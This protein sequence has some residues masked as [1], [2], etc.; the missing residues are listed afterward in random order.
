MQNQNDTLAKNF[1]VLLSSQA[2]TWLLSLVLMIFLPR[3]LGPTNVGKL[4]LAIALWTVLEVVMTFGSDEFVVKAIARDTSRASTF[5]G[6]K[7]FLNSGIFVFC[8]I[9]L[10]YT[11]RWFDYPQITIYVVMLIGLEYWIRLFVISAESVLQGMETMEHISIGRILG[12]FFNVVVGVTLLLLG[13]KIFMICAVRIATAVTVFV[14]QYYFLQQTAKF[15]PQVDRKL[16]G[17]FFKEGWPYFLTGISMVAYMQLDIVILSALVNEETIGWY[18]T[19]DQLFGTLLFIPSAFIMSAYPAYVKLS[20]NEFGSLQKLMAKNFDSMLLLG[21]PM[22][23]G[24]LMI[25]N[26]LVLLLYGTG[27]EKSGPVLSAF[28]IVLILTYL[29]MLVGQFLIAIDRHKPWAFVMAIALLLTIP[30][31]YLLIPWTHSAFGNGALGGAFAFIITE[32]GMLLCGFA[33]L[34]QGTLGNANV[35]TTIRVVIAG[36]VMVGSI[37]WLREYF[38]AIPIIT[39][40]VVY[41]GMVLLLKIVPKEDIDSLK[42]MARRMF[43][44]VS[45]REATAVSH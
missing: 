23:L 30:L 40:V 26:Q 41:V 6:T 1:V 20:V 34:P 21:V 38:I 36:L 5:F 4:Y 12:Q 14:V 2:V 37:W 31:D 19:A 7:S 39:G 13:W 29:N 42:E 43:A 22:G 16:F 10:Y 44:R 28:G 15:R 3:Y 18:G 33:L 27:F 32:L 17:T 25:G 11:L 8:F 9:A 35:R 45:R 24:L